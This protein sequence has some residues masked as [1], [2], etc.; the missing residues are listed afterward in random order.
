MTL[1]EKIRYGRMAIACV[2]VVA[3]GLG[4]HVSPLGEVAGG[5]GTAN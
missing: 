3:V 1:D 4:I 2:A 5:A